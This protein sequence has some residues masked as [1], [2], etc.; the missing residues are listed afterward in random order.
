MTI[1]SEPGHGT[2]VEIL[3]PQVE[4][5]AEPGLAAPSRE[6]ST[7]GTETI[8]LAEDAAYVREFTREALEGLGYTVFAPGDGARALSLPEEQLRRVA[9]LVTDVIM[10][11][12]SG[13]ELVRRLREARPGLKVVF[14]SGYT[15]A[16]LDD[17]GGLQEG[18][19]FLQKP[20]SPD[21]LARA[22][23]GLLDVPPPC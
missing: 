19:S 8:L 20:F 12:V 21:D 9:V 23:R 1:R 11:G 2:T 17:R 16:W 5:P 13:P 15:G 4:G 6:V 18:E 14:I 22:I 7:R 3:L 10:P